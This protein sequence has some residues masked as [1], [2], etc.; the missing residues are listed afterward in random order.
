MILKSFFIAFFATLFV[1][2]SLIIRGNSPVAIQVASPLPDYLVNTPLVQGLD[3]WKPKSANVLQ[4]TIGK[5]Q[6]SAKAAF[7]YDIT[8]DTVLY[9]KNGR[10]RLPVASLVKVMTAIVALESKSP[11]T[12][13]RVSP[14]AATTGENS[15]GISSG[16]RYTL[17]ELLY[18]L[19]LHSGNDAAVAIAESTA[20]TVDDFTKLMNQKAKILG[21]TDTYFA[22]PSGLEDEKDGS[23]EYSTAYDLAI[24]SK[25]ALTLPTFSKVAATVE[26]EIPYSS[27]HKYLYFYNQTNLLTSYPG[28]KGVKT[29]YTPSAGLCLITY[30]E[31]GGHKLI[32]VILN[33][34]SRR[35]EMKELLNYSFAL[36][37]V[38]VPGRP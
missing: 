5:P 7:I 10:E 31:N 25:H 20:A 2:A 38:K 23:Q 32:G 9:D 6:V 16:E 17:E 8:T 12:L 21:L 22:N 13:V 27:D 18:G 34:E 26:Y 11:T 35:E 19:V 28:V 15:M 1:A 3:F 29:G 36:L 30:V 33:S 4:S 37:G 14:N 24:I